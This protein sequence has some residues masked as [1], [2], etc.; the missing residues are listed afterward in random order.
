MEQCGSDVLVTVKSQRM[1]FV[2]RN[3]VHKG[4]YCLGCVPV[5]KRKMSHIATSYTQL[6]YA[7]FAHV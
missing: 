3:K 5:N 4:H 6:E 2:I 1:V 7:H